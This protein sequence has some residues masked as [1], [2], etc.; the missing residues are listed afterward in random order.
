MMEMSYAQMAETILSALLP[1]F[2]EEEVKKCVQDAYA[3][4]FDNDDITPLHIAK[5]VP[6]LELFHGP[7]CAF[8]DVGLRMLPQLMS[9]AIQSCKGKDV[10]I[11]TATSGDTGKA[12]LE[13]FKDVEHIGITVFYPDHGVSNMQKL[14]M[15]TTSGQNT[16]VCAIQGNF[17]D[18]QS[19]VKKIFQDQEMKARLNEMNTT[20]SSANSINIGRLIP[21]IVYYVFAYKEIDVYKRQLYLYVVIIQ[22]VFENH[23]LHT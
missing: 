14:Q 3:N 7:T 1:D 18:A 12:A 9:T 4:R 2:T 15:V 19:N 21:Q 23:S 17:D 6:V 22:L 20:L 16:K 13:G 8:K 5:D 10:M 11:L